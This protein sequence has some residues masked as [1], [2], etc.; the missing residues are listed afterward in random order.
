MGTQ[1]QP[2]ENDWAVSCKTHACD[3]A[4][5]RLGVYPWEREDYLHTNIYSTFI[6]NHPKL[7]GMPLENG[8]Q[9]YIHTVGTAQQH[10]HKSCRASR[11]GW[12]SRAP[13]QVR[14]A[15]LKGYLV[16]DS[17][18]TIPE[19]TSC[20]EEQIGGCQRLRIWGGSDDKRG[21]A[22]GNFLQGWGNVLYLCFDG[23]VAGDS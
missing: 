23:C 9:W 19:K 17:V 15:K 16:D 21:V 5:P 14:E 7:E 4:I 11:Q 8:R 10:T 13:C 6:R 1:I 2:L 3:P 12:L 22:W 20:S 18:D